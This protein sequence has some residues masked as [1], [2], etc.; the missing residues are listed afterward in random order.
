[1]LS[2]PALLLASGTAALM[3]VYELDGVMHGAKRL[4]YWRQRAHACTALAAPD[5]MWFAMPAEVTL[6]VASQ[7]A[8]WQLSTAAQLAALEAAA[9]VAAVR[10]LSRCDVVSHGCDG[11]RVSRGWD[12]GWHAVGGARWVVAGEPP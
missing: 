10:P 7:F 12:H 2:H 1:M 3:T 6:T 4:W 8:A 9:R 5:L 11:G